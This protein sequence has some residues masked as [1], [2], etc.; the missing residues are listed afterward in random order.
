MF[1]IDGDTLTVAMGKAGS[2]NRP[3]NFEGGEGVDVV[4]LKRNK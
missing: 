2:K 1:I 4:T 3:K